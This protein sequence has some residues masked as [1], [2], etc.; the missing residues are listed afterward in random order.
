MENYSTVELSFFAHL[1][2]T[3][4]AKIIT[5]ASLINC[6]KTIGK[7]LITPL[8]KAHNPVVNNL[9]DGAIA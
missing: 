4:L 5:L 3:F 2:L 7:C 6:Q 9:N 8:N 1:A